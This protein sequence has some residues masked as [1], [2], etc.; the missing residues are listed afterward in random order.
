M[1]AEYFGSAST[2]TINN[3]PYADLK[4]LHLTKNIGQHGDFFKPLSHFFKMTAFGP[5]RKTQLATRFGCNQPT[6]LFAYA[7][8]EPYRCWCG[9]NL[10]SPPVRTAEMHRTIKTKHK[11][12][13]LP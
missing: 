5:G 8:R 3:R 11:L 9:T 7:S 4:D 10:P 13:S 6:G 1:A 12:P 2:R